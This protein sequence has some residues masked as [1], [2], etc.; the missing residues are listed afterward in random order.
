MF[1][2]HSF[3]QIIFPLFIIFPIATKCPEDFLFGSETICRPADPDL[4]CDAD[5]RCNSVDITCPHT[6]QDID[7]VCR[8]AADDCDETEYCLGTS[9]RCPD[10]LKRPP[11]SSCNDAKACTTPDTCNE[12]G[13]CTGKQTDFA[14]IFHLNCLFLGPSICTCISD[15]DCDDSNTCTTEKCDL[16][17]PDGGVCTYENAPLGTVCRPSRG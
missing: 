17:N 10:D 5:D 13:V 3:F 1:Q 16:S 6:Y 12:N 15:A 14:L 7:F 11:G 4:P 2:F 8:E 9:S